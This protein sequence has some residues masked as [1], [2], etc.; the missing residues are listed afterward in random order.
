[1]RAA[2]SATPA[3][4][5]AEPCERDFSVYPAIDVRA[6][7]V[8]R[9][10]QGDYARETRYYDDPFQLACEYAKVG[11]RWLHLV[12]LDAARIGQYSLLPLVGKLSR[13]AALE[14]QTGGGVREQA[15]VEALLT[16]GAARVVIGTLA[17]THTAT[18]VEWIK[19]FGADRICVAVDV[20][21][22][23]TDRWYAATHGWTASAEAEALPLITYLA[24]NGL[25][26]LLSTDIAR[27]G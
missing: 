16:A 13:E 14:V 21:R 12:D 15:D 8:V 7:Q 3:G 17:V 26:H 2:A 4:R 11:A 1:M 22:D 9:L 6:G 18:V 23:A 5:A 19:H 24:E 20:R 10:A 25:R 27:D